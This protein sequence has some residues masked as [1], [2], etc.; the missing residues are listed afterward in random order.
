MSKAT[1]STQNQR[2]LSFLQNG[3]T[4]TAKQAR[5][6]FGVT[7]VGKRISELRAEGH[8]IYTN[9]K[10][11]TGTTSY[12]LGRPSRAM[13]AAAYAVLGSELFN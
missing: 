8:A 6:M 2:I 9:T 5:S 13:V 11:S 1:T 7:A 10:T 3:N 12:R 4:L